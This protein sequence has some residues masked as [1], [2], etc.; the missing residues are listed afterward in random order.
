[1][2]TI[3]AL[4]AAAALAGPALAQDEPRPKAEVVERDADGRATKVS[5]DGKVYEVCRD[6]KTDG[7]INPR[8]AGLDFGSVP[9]D[10]WPGKPASEGRK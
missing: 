10:H 6:G 5:V 7:C 3:A 9:L 2:K 8:D 4:L 1:M